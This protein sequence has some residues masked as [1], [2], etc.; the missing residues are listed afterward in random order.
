MQTISTTPISVE[1]VDQ[2]LPQTQCTQCGYPSCIDYATAITTAGA[3]IN[4]CPPGGDLTIQG[5]ASL[6]D[7][8]PAPLDPECGTYR[9]P[10]VAIISEKDCIGC[11]LCIQACPVD[12]IVGSAKLMHTVIANQCTGCHLCVDPC[13]VDCIKMNPVDAI[14]DGGTTRWPMRSYENVMN[15]RKNFQKKQKRTLEKAE[16]SKLPQDRERL[17]EEIATIVT[18]QKAL[19]RARQSC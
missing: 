15:G 13:P 9:D 16:A 17:R 18:R 12:A 10:E 14:V 4:R 6:L 5:L 1:V 3:P 8:K 19:R 7:L 2:W 11:T